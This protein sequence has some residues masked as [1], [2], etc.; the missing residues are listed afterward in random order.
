MCNYLP[1]GINVL[2]II[3][4]DM[5]Q[6]SYLSFYITIRLH[7]F[8]IAIKWKNNI[9]YIDVS[10]LKNWS[11]FLKSQFLKS[12]K[13]RISVILILI[14]NIKFIIRLHYRKI[15]YKIIL[16]SHAILFNR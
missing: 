6:Q 14:Y 10:S 11:P 8:Y 7:R 3:N 15:I 16:N 13:I 5:N 2:H 1:Q 4:N 9:F 12:E